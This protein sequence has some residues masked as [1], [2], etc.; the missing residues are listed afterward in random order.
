MVYFE[1]LLRINRV[2]Y[3]I[4]YVS[5]LIEYATDYL[6]RLNLHYMIVYIVSDYTVV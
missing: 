5:D 6:E 4:S 2:H 1:P 3:S